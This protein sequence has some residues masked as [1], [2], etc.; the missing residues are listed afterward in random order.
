MYWEIAL[1][2]FWWWILF[3]WTLKL[4]S[5]VHSNV[6]LMHWFGIIRK[7]QNRKENEFLKIG[8]KN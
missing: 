4:N 6:I 3:K 8:D 1:V 2:P 7:D 5:N